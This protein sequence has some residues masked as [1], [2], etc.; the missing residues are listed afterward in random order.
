MAS[1]VIPF[2]VRAAKPRPD[3]DA[4]LDHI[5]QIRSVIATSPNKLTVEM[6]RFM[7]EWYERDGVF[8]H[9]NDNIIPLRRA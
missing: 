9:Q 8:D 7:I 5:S 1:N 6:G 4:A 3:L 2:P